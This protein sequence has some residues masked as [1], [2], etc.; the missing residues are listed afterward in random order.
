MAAF[1]SVGAATAS[2]VQAPISPRYTGWRT[3]RYGPLVT[4]AR[5]HGDHVT[6]EDGGIR[7]AAMGFCECEYRADRK[8]AGYKRDRLPGRAPRE[9]APHGESGERE[10][11]RRAQHPI[12][13]DEPGP[14]ARLGDRDFELAGCVEGCECRG[15]R[16]QA[17]YEPAG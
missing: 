4:S 2:P 8:R 11:D 5:S 10:R 14:C 9:S 16:E 7:R 15:E 6:H 17:R 13:G 12:E 1:A 3:S